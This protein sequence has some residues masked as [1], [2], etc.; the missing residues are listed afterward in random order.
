MR[1]NGKK[2]EGERKG[3]GV[4]EGKGIFGRG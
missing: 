2:A 3:I 4:V 1:A